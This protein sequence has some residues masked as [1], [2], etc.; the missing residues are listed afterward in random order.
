MVKSVLG[1]NHRGLTDWSIQR[2]SA[3]LLAIYV[4]GLSLYLGLHS[5]ISYAEWHSLF[6]Q[7]WMKIAT[8]LVLLSLLFHAWIGIWTV[9][10]DYVKNTILNLLI[11]VIVLL[12]LI[13]FFFIGLQ[14]VWGV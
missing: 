9:L 2:V 10:T 3:I 1:V 6:A 12:A 13:A 4:F 8:I 5:D 7:T 14:I 11:Q